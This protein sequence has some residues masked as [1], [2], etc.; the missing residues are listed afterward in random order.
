MRY[1]AYILTNNQKVM[2]ENLGIYLPFLIK[3][4]LIIVWI[5]GAMLAYKIKDQNNRVSKLVVTALSIA[6]TG[7]VASFIVHTNMLSQYSLGNI[8][9]ETLSMTNTALQIGEVALQVV[10]FILLLL[11][12]LKPTHIKNKVEKK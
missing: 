11:A 1:N 8:S 3:L 4:P 10:T 6:I 12:I 7:V 2:E 5:A 9:T